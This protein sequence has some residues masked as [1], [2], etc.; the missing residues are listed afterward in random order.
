MKKLILS[1]LLVC[2]LLTP[3]CAFL[4]EKEGYIYQGD[5]IEVGGDGEPIE[6]VNNPNATNPTYAQL[7]AFIVSDV[8]NRLPYID[9]GPDGFVCSDFA[10]VLHNNAEAAGIKAAWVGIDL[11]QEEIG[12]AANAFQTTDRGLVYIDCTGEMLKIWMGSYYI[13]AEDY[14]SYELWMDDYDIP[15]SVQLLKFDTVAYVV[16][17]KEY[18]TIGINEADSLNYDFYVDYMQAWDEYEALLDDYNTDV[19]LY[20]AE[21]EGRVYIEGTE[22]YK[23]IQSWEAELIEKEQLLLEMEDEL[24]YFCY[25]TL[26]IVEKIHIHW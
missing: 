25:Y 19:M 17:G 18:G 20:N 1:I 23:M 11:Y 24:G 21:I 2:L 12:H 13:S 15:A 5:Y 6:L 26:G 7:V 8:T 3:S 9:G 14:S 22:E 10:E 16:E 4:F